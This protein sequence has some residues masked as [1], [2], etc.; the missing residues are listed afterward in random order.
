MP[1]ARS[2]QQASPTDMDATEKEAAL[3]SA[4]PMPGTHENSW[5]LTLH[6]KLD[7]V[8][9]YKAGESV[10]AI[11]ALYAIQPSMVRYHARKRGL[12]KT[13]HPK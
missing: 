11:A 9:R 10:R 5:K 7:I 2:S 6:D 4:H 13:N 8:R 3:D 1:T 12:L